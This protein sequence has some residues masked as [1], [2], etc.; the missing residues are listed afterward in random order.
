MFVGF[1]CFT[2]T[3]TLVLILSSEQNWSLGKKMDFNISVLPTQS[4]DN[5]GDCTTTQAPPG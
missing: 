4:F 5:N 2:P 3:R 1:Y